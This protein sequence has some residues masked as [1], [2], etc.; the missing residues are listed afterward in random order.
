MSNRAPISSLNIFWTTRDTRRDTNIIRNPV[1][2]M[3]TQSSSTSLV[4]AQPVLPGS[5]S[6]VLFI[7][8]RRKLPHKMRRT[9]VAAWVV[10]QIQL[11]IILRVPPSARLEDLRR[12]GLTLPPLFLRL[13]RDLLR[14]RFLLRRMIED[15]GAVLCAR[16]HPLAVLGRGIVHFVEELEQGRVL[17]LGGIED[18][19]E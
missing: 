3:V 2:S 13:L 19:L 18:Y 15:R 7:L 9:L 17:D 1:L 4:Y 11:M 8:Q 14:L 10:M 6:N 12:D 16:I 5:I